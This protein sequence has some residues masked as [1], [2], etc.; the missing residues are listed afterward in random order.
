MES[1]DRN[2]H[3][4]RNRDLRF[5]V[6]VDDDLLA[7]ADAVGFL[8]VDDVAV[9]SRFDT[10]LQRRLEVQRQLVVEGDE[11]QLAAAEGHLIL[12]IVSPVADGRIANDVPELDHV[13]DRLPSVLA[14]PLPLTL[15]ITVNDPSDDVLISISWWTLIFVLK[16]KRTHD[17]RQA[18]HM[19]QHKSVG[20][21]ILS[22]IFE[23]Y[24]FVAQNAESP[25]DILIVD[26][27]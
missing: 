1:H 5:P 15:T 7:G 9:G 4:I 8:P 12:P 10:R 16:L 21:Q 20:Q 25:L 26:E 3:L 2:F 23:R 11:A 14:H 13:D 24:H 18:V 27:H 6:F 19:R 22:L 17:A